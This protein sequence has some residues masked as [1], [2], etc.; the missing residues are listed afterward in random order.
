MYGD[1]Q[2]DACRHATRAQ[3]A[4]PSH[5]QQLSKAKKLLL[6]VSLGQHQQQTL[7]SGSLEAK[8][9][10]HSNARAAHPVE[11]HAQQSI[12][13]GSAETHTHTKTLS[14]TRVAAATRSRWASSLHW[15]HLIPHELALLHEMHA[16]NKHNSYRKYNTQSAQSIVWKTRQA[17]TLQRRMVHIQLVMLA[18]GIPNCQS[19][20]LLP[21][22]SPKLRYT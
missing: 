16:A 10:T 15:T 17:H 19:C 14:N 13:T 4:A 7:S 2:P 18:K 3:W 22:G 11:M 1:A 5:H 12:D 6:E 9:T 20:I 8:T 21:S